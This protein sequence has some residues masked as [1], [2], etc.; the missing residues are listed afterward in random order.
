[1]PFL[2]RHPW[3]PLARVSS[4]FAPPSLGA[5]KMIEREREGEREGEK[6][7]DTVC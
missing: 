2:S 6:K 4:L 1:L 7:R 3:S 5:M